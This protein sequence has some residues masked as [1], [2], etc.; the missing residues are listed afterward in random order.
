M[1]SLVS[2]L[3]ALLLLCPGCVP[4]NYN[5]TARM[6]RD[7]SNIKNN[8]LITGQPRNRFQS[9]WGPPT[10]TYSRRFEKGAHSEYV[11]TPFGGGGSFAARGGETYDLWFYEERKVTLIFDR[12]G[13]LAYWHWG[14]DSPDEKKM[15]ET[16][17]INM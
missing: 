12:K 1:K 4:F 6:Y 9:V 14:A 10:R 17:K 5:A 2:S 15:Y 3:A 11:W 16:E 8:I 7:K 13:E